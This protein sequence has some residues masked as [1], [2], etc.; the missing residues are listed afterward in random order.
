MSVYVPPTLTIDGVLFQ[1]IDGEL[2]VLLI[3]RRAAPFKG[4]RALPG[5]YNPQGETTTQAL[6]RILKAKAGVETQRL[7]LVE[8]LYTVDNVGRDPR[9]HAVSIVYTGLGYGVVPIAGKTTEDPEFFP[10]KRLPKLAFDHQAIVGHAIERLA[11]KITY[12]NIVYALLPVEFTQSQLQQAYE[13]ILDRP[14]DKRNFRKKFLALEIIESTG[15]FLKE[16][17]HRPAQL[18]RF[19]KHEL[20]LL[21]RDF[22]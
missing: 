1:I 11:S 21:A 5:G 3:K 9:G 15:Q 17:A 20:E 19:K 18:F 6:S 2:C 16:G 4:E 13:V 10:V 14:L 12:T 22:D 7:G 8:Q